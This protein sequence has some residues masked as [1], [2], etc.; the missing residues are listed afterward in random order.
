M[1]VVSFLIL[2]SALAATVPLGAPL[3]DSSQQRAQMVHEKFLQEHPASVAARLA[4]AE[5]LSEND[6]LRAAVVHWRTA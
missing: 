1:R 5:F 3:S 2:L 6:N 4:Y